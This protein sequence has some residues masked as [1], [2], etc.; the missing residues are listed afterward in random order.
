MSRGASGHF[1]E[2]E[3]LGSRWIAPPL[4]DPLHSARERRRTIGC[5]AAASSSSLSVGRTSTQPS[6][7]AEQQP[8][9][10]KPCERQQSRKRQSETPSG[11]SSAS[12]SSAASITPSA[13]LSPLIRRG[14]AAA[15]SQPQ[16]VRR[17]RRH[18]E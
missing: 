16:P 10:K 11:R 13:R 1:A 17:R 4:W 14:S 3:V 9:R 6:G 18:A 8:T 2:G 15:R 12:P 7:L 5:P